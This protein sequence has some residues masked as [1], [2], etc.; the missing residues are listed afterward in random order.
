MY[1]HTVVFDGC[2]QRAGGQA[3]YCIG[4]TDGVDARFGQWIIK[5]KSGPWDRKRENG[6]LPQYVQVALILTHG[7]QEFLEKR[8][9]CGYAYCIFDALF[10]STAARERNAGTP[11]ILNQ[12]FLDGIETGVSVAKQS[13][14]VLECPWMS[15]DC[16][17][18]QSDGVTR[19]LLQPLVTEHQLT[20]FGSR[21]RP[22]VD[23]V[24]IVGSRGHR[25]PAGDNSLPD[26]AER[27]SVAKI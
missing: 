6:C 12:A 8:V 13:I 23:S 20:D 10:H 14:K 25:I 15:A 27:R 22:Q 4:E 21:K 9:D 17:L 1:E 19:L 11:R 5:R 26:F 18:N 16:A 24:K 7:S 2:Q 3:L